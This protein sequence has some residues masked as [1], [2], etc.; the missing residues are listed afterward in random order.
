[1]KEVMAVGLNMIK[2]MEIITIMM[3]NAKVYENKTSITPL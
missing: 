2:I 3:K 1:M